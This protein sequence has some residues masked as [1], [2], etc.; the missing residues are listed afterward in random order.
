[1]S[2]LPLGVYT[3]ATIRLLINLQNSLLNLYTKHLGFA[4]TFIG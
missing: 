4:Y 1:M 3:A 2:S